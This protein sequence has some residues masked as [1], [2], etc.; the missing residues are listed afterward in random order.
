MPKERGEK[1][2]QRSRRA[3]AK[4][5]LIRA[6]AWTLALPSPIRRAILF[7]VDD[8]DGRPGRPVGA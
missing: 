4:D 1:T 6:I 7:I 3:A 5:G 2:A 8:L